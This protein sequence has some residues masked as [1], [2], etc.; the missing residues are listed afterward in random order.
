MAD[1]PGQSHE[2]TAS[3]FVEAYDAFH[4]KNLPRNSG[5][6]ALYEH[7]AR[8]TGRRPRTRLRHRPR[9]LA[10]PKRPQIMVRHKL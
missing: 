5:N 6:I 1:A 4:D 10:H 8:K 2:E 9:Y 3:L 7:L